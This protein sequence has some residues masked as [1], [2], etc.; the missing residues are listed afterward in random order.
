MKVTVV[1]VFHPD[2][3]HPDCVRKRQHILLGYNKTYCG[4]KGFDGFG[5][6]V[7][8]HLVINLCDACKRLAARGSA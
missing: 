2:K 8:M 3:R 1:E 6:E 7:E 4:L 5:Q